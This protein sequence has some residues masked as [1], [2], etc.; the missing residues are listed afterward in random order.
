MSIIRMSRMRAL[1]AALAATL[2]L[3]ACGSGNSTPDTTVPEVSLRIV[4]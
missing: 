1:T 2:V 4:S 3:G